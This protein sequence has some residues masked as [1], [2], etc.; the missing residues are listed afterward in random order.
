MYYKMSKPCIRP[1][2][3][4]SNYGTSQLPSIPV[5][6]RGDVGLGDDTYLPVNFKQ[7]NYKRQMIRLGTIGDGSCFFHAVLKA[8]YEPYA[9]N[10]SYSFRTN[11]VRK[12]RNEL[13]M[14]LEMINPETGLR[15]Y[16]TANNGVWKELANTILLDDMNRRIDYSLRGMQRLLASNDFIGDEVFSYVADMLG[17]DLYV[18]KLDIDEIRPVIAV[19]KNRPAV[20]IGGNGVHYETLGVIRDE[21]IQTVFL[22]DDE[23]IPIMK[24]LFGE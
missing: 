1:G 15:Y 8:Y 21:L 9:S 22:P 3:L 2:P 5:I 12:L 10:P 18:M 11:M 16:D 4:N 14:V 13:S 7:P 20:I 23:I 17:I 24:C 6:K 19:R